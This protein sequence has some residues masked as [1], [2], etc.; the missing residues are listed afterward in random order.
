MRKNRRFYVTVLLI[1]LMSLFLCAYRFIDRIRNVSRDEQCLHYWLVT[2]DA[3]ANYIS[4]N[5]Q[6]PSRWSEVSLEASDNDWAKF[7]AENGGPQR[8]VVI[9]FDTTLDEL[10]EDS[11]LLSNYLFPRRSIPAYHVEWA[12]DRVRQAIINCRTYKDGEGP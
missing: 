3:L 7:I 1:F 2:T 10:S 4:G 9:N 12:I 8:Y 5:C 6:W 11:T